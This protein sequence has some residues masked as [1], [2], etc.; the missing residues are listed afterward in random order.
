MQ[1]KFFF[2]KHYRIRLK[3]HLHTVRDIL[4]QS[5]SPISRH[6][7]AEVI[8]TV[9][10]SLLPQKVCERSSVKI[11]NAVEK[12]RWSIGP[13]TENAQSD[14][15]G[16]DEKQEDR[17]ECCAEAAARAVTT[18]IRRLGHEF[19]AGAVLHHRPKSVRRLKAVDG[20]TWLRF[21]LQKKRGRHGDSP[22]LGRS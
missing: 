13:L 15:G 17:A 22:K 5:A 18:A 21:R 14:R 7:L 16:E 4:Q 1:K 3:I 20:L 11:R 12:C 6:L 8:A 10:K 2:I 19:V 9:Q